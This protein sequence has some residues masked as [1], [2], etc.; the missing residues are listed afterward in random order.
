MGEGY[1]W[2]KGLESSFFQVKERTFVYSFLAENTVYDRG[3]D[4]KK[5]F[6]SDL[7]YETIANP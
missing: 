1:Y 3:H 6:V 4:K 2:S 5:P 7:L